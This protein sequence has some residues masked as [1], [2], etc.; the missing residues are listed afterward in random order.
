MAIAVASR[1]PPRTPIA[2][3]LAPA[4]PASGRRVRSCSFRGAG[5]AMA[6]AASATLQVERGIAAIPRLQVW[7]DSAL[8]CAGPQR[9]S[10]RTANACGCVCNCNFGMTA[11]LVALDRS[12]AVIVRLTRAAVCVTAVL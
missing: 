7:N 4:L 8:G 2:R 11:L 12:D 9:C 5:L 6:T 3:K 1:L 10:Y